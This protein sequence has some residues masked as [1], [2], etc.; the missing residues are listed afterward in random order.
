[1]RI[2]LYLKITNLF[3]ISSFILGFIFKENLSGGGLIDSF[4]IINN[5]LLFKEN[6]LFKID[7]SKYESSSLPIYYVITKFII[8]TNYYPQFYLSCFNFLISI[9]TILTFYK[10]L[11]IKNK[12]QSFNWGVLII[13]TIPMLS[14]FFRTSAFWALEENI[15]Y[16]FYT[17]TIVC[18][19]KSKKIKKYAYFAILLSC[20]TFYA[21]QNYAFLPII[22]FFLYF[23]FKKILKKENFIYIFLFIL[24]LFP[25]LYFF[26]KWDGIDPAVLSDQSGLGRIEFARENIL[27][28]LTNY[29]LYLLPFC[30]FLNY[31]NL[32]K[33]INKE[34]IKILVT[35]IILFFLFILFFLNHISK[36]N[37]YFRIQLGGGMIYKFIFHYNFLIAN[38]YIQKILY[39]LISLFGFILIVFFSSKNRNFSIFCLISIIIFSNVKIIFQEYFDPLIYFS[40]IFFTNVIKFNN[41]EIFKKIL[42]SSY[43]FIIFLIA[44]IFK[45]II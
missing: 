20:L 45:I 41:S 24:M 10:C 12:I 31:K 17:T 22:I 2:K 21:R 19:L 33:K 26:Y 42:F 5:F 11:C 23:D 9:L 38:F 29:F 6:S 30:F 40:T 1:M 3:I 27:I 43:Y 37:S 14:P 34:K 7:W 36:D 16:F 25:S 44:Y 8:P 18:Y 28:V 35:F 39:I 32:K 4:H 15:G 13:S